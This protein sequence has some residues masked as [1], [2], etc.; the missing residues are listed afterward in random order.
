MKIL[1]TSDHAGFDMKEAIFKSL[2]DDILKP[3]INFGPDNNEP[4][5][6]PVYAKL[7]CEKMA[8]NPEKYVGI[9]ICGTGLGMSMA[10]NRFT[11]IR[12]GVCR[13]VDDVI[14]TRKHNNDNVV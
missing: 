13:T 1:I 5:D 9:L 11:H 12:A 3:I 2:S 14:M 7:V 8:E 10:A 4:C 6:Y